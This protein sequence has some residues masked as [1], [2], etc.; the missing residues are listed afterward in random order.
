MVGFS[1]MIYHGTIRK[2]SSDANPSFTGAPL[3]FPA[4]PTSACVRRGGDVLT[5]LRGR[6]GDKP[7]RGGVIDIPNQNALQKEPQHCSQ[8]GAWIIWKTHGFFRG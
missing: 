7:K 5:N 4:S 6:L 3:I 2:K 1:M 8:K